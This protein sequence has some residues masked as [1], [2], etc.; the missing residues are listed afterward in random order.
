MNKD[1]AAAMHRAVR[2]MRARDLMGATRI[3]QDALAGRTTPANDTVPRTDAP[4][5][6][7]KPQPAEPQPYDLVIDEEGN[8]VA[9]RAD[10]ASS[11]PASARSKRKP[12]AKSAPMSASGR[13]RQPLDDVVRVLRE[14]RAKAKVD[15][16]A[17]KGRRKPDIAVPPGAQFLTRS[18]TGAAGT[19]AYK[20]YIPGCDRAALRGLLVMLHGCKQNP[21]DFAAGTDMNAVAESHRLVVAYPGQ[22]DIANGLSCWNWFDLNDQARGIGEPSILAGITQDLMAEFA[23][24]RSRVFVA[25]LSAGGAMAVVMGETYPDLFAAVGVHSGLPYGAANDVVSAFAAMRGERPVTQVNDPASPRTAPVRM[26][27]FQGD[28]DKTVHPSNAEGIV[29]QAR[30]IGAPLRIE[31]SRGSAGERAYTRTTFVAANGDCLIDYWL[32]DGAGHAWSGGRA[33][34]SYTDPKGPDASTEMVRFFL[35]NGG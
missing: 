19:R 17:L 26:M 10:G 16:G 2:S 3:I 8:I 32:I 11:S 7:T 15:I 35:G 4:V 21:D 9:P 33:T 25:G 28:A 27:I 18:F 6:D 24:D 31:Q 23:I 12:S 22:S 34:G 29:A 20:L 14:V 1:F 13:M 5:P 30:G